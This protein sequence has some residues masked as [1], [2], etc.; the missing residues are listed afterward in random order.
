MPAVDAAPAPGAE[1]GGVPRTELQELQHRA[2]QNTDEVCQ[3][4]RTLFN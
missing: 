2:Q 3:N 4:E 1:N